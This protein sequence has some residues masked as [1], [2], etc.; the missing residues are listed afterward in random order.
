MQN[1]KIHFSVNRTELRELHYITPISNVG[2][3]CQ[4]GIL[5]HN[6]VASVPHRSVAAEVIQDRRAQVRVPKGRPLHDYAN[7]Y[8]CAR[9]PMM[10]KRKSGHPELCVLRV[11][12]GVLD[13]PGTVIADGNASSEYVLFAP[14]PSGLRHVDRDRTFAEYWTS[15][16]PVEYYRRKSAKCAEVLVPDRVEPQYLLGGYVSSKAGIR[17]LAGTCIAAGVVVDPGVFFQSES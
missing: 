10:Y 1:D 16:D 14:A 7:L 4:Q 3:I 2:S 6:R 15:Q 11:S 12:P 13:L 5:S 9:N 8:I 17:L